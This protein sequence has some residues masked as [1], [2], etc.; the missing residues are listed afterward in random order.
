MQL[1]EEPRVPDHNSDP[2]HVPGDGWVDEGGASHLGPATHTYRDRDG[3]E[4]TDES[5]VEA[6]EADKAE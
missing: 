5:D 3:V 1:I 6:D 4:D 2:A